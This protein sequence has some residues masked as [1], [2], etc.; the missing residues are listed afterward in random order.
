[1]DGKASHSIN[2]L[3]IEYRCRKCRKI[4]FNDQHIFQ[5]KISS[6]GNVADD[7]AVDSVNCNF[8]YFLSPMDWMS[9]NE[10]RGKVCFVL[11]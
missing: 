9:L 8:G 7:E 5:H 3:N 1:M 2:P 11:M 4:L 10:H 6:S